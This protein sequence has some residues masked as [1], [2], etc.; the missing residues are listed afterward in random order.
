VGVVPAEVKGES[1]Y[2]SWEIARI[3]LTF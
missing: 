1:A 3:R 2:F